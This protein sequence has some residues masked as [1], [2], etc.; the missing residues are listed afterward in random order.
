LAVDDKDWAKHGRL[1]SFNQDEFLENP[2]D[3]PRSKTGVAENGFIYYPDTCF[4]LSADDENANFPSFSP[5][6]A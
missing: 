2:D 1:Y 5:V 4:N 3:L 6:E